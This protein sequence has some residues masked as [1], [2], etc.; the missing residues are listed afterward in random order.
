MADAWEQRASES[1]EAY[2]A[3]LAYRDQGLGKRSIRDLSRQLGKSPSLVARWSSD[4]GWMERAAS[5]DAHLQ[6][7]VQAE[8]EEELRAAVKRQAQMAGVFLNKVVQRLQQLDP[9]DLTPSQM[10]QWF[11]VAARVERTAFG[12]P[13][14]VI[15]G[16][17]GNTEHSPMVDPGRVI[18]I[19]KWLELTDGDAEEE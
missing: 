10:I 13:D 5:W 15:E 7:V 1:G 12:Q 11:D 4:N 14:M 19:R 6:R 8:F 9:A 17:M 18:E 2:A 3:F 16:R